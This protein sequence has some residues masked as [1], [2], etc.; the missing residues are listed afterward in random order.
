MSTLL[1]HFTNDKEAFEVL[2]D[3]DKLI[4]VLSI[5]QEATDTYMEETRK[6]LND[7]RRSVQEQAKEALELAECII[8]AE[9]KLR[10]LELYNIVGLKSRGMNVISDA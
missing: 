2:M 6:K 7:P 8:E 1:K 4:Q 10:E 5:V 3:P 9:K